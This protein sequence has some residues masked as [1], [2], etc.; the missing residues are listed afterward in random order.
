M[1]KYNKHPLIKVIV[2][3]IIFRLHDSANQNRIAAYHFLLLALGH[4]PKIFTI[5]DN[6]HLFESLR[7]HLEPLAFLI[8]LPPDAPVSQERLH[9]ALQ[10]AFW[11]AK[12]MTLIEMVQGPLPAF[13]VN[14]AFLCLLCFGANEWIQKHLKHAEEAEILKIAAE[15]KEKDI[16]C[17]LKKI[18]S[19]PLTCFSQHL[20]YFLMEREIMKGKSED[21]LAIIE[22]FS[23]QVTEDRLPCDILFIWIC[24]L[25]K[26]WQKARQLLESYPQA[27]LADEYSP[28]YPLMGCY[29]RHAEGKQI[30]L[31]HL[32]LSIDLPYP[33]TSM[34]LSFYLQGK[35]TEKKG[36]ISTAF[37]W[38][39]LQL[40]RQLHLYY[41][42]AA[43]QQKA[44]YYLNQMKRELKRLPTLYA[45]P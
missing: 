7:A 22:P 33:P 16:V 3:H 40:L 14:N 5:E 11:L 39:K 41:H 30:A 28:L 44:S 24:L 37:K 38:E 35:I 31:T 10:I 45:Y 34:L 26:K 17:V 12:P 1:R 43:E 21:L 20:A 8:P 42:C 25:Q 9:V 29:L 18:L 19:S 23:A 36:W 27:V 15:A 13:V 4:L 32:S 6:A 2:E